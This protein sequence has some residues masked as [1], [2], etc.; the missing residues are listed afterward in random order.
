MK[1]KQLW[2]MMLIVV[3]PM[4]A[5]AQ[6]EFTKSPFRATAVIKGVTYNIWAD[7]L[8]FNPG[9]PNKPDSWATMQYYC[10]IYCYKCAPQVWGRAEFDQARLRES[11]RDQG[12]VPLLSMAFIPLNFAVVGGELPQPRP[13]FRLSG[14]DTMVLILRDGRRLTS[15]PP[16]D[17]PTTSLSFKTPTEKSM[18]ICAYLERQLD[19]VMMQTREELDEKYYSNDE[20]TRLHYHDH[21]W[22]VISLVPIPNEGKEFSLQDVAAMYIY[23]QG[24]K[25]DLQ[26]QAVSTLTHY[27]GR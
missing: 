26:S 22:A 17:A 2:M 4:V 6:M 27:I 21:P 23:F 16:V 12:Y 14:R 9:H 13:T 15:Y 1:F 11:L 8:A 20:S 5:T 19:G 25:V 24:L 7:E 18:A 3:W 10:R